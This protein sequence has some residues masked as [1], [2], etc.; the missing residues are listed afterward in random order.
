[1]PVLSCYRDMSRTPLYVRLPTAHAERLDRAAF[2]L[3]AS[4]QDIV[5]G[6]IAHYVNP[7]APD[8]LRRIVIDALEEPMG[9]G[10]HSFTA[11]TGDVLTLEQLAELLQVD[12][13]DARALAEAGDIPGRRIGS[14]WRFARV[15]VLRWL[16]TDA[17]PSPPLRGFS[18]EA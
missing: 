17:V 3:K 6:L 13:D 4:K 16:A 7:S 18:P 12:E 2:E 1:M 14:Q 11:V 15:A 10:S 5:T 9:T 8:G